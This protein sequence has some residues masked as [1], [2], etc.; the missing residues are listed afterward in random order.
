MLLNYY[1]NTTYRGGKNDGAIIVATLC[2][3]ILLNASI[4]IIIFK[5]FNNDLRVFRFSCGKR[6]VKTDKAFC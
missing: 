4:S 2:F 6:R 1:T 5:K 3:D